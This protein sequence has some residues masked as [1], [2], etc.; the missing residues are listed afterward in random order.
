[1]IDSVLFGLGWGLVDL[2]SALASLSYG[3]TGG[4]IF[5]AAM[6]IGMGAAPLLSRQLDSLK[7]AS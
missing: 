2:C 4:L 3:G 1:M 6:L 5:L 7:A